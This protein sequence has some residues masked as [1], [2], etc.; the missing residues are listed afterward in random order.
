MHWQRTRLVQRFRY[1][2]QDHQA[3]LQLFRL[4]LL[5]HRQ[6][7]QQ[8][9]NRRGSRFPRSRLPV[10][11][12]LSLIPRMLRFSGLP[13]RFSWASLAQFKNMWTKLRAELQLLLRSL[14]PDDKVAS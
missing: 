10:V 6:R 7:S 9:C 14:N 8:C 13:P 1:A 2:P 11:L 4:L 5:P 12:I 3:L